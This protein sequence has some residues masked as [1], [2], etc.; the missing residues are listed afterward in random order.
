M[1]KKTAVI[2]IHGIG[3]QVPMETLN[4]FVDTVWT[5]DLSLA[6]A[7]KPDPNTGEV[8]T[9]NAS[10]S[11]PDARN[12]S[13]ELQ[14][15]TTESDSDGRRV[16]FFEY[17]W[18]HRVTGTTWEQV[19]AWL[20]GL[21]L[22]NP[23]TNVPK[24][25]L[26]AWTV[27]WL[28]FFVFL[29]ISLIAGMG[30]SKDVIDPA[31]ASFPPIH[32]TL[33]L[34]AWVQAW[35]KRLIA[36]VWG[37]AG[38]VSGWILTVMVDVAGDVVRYVQATP[39]N[40]AIRQSI[41]ENGVQLLETLMG[42]DEHGQQGRTEYDRIIVVGHSLGTIVAYDILTHAFGRHNTRLDPAKVKGM[43]QEN[44]V[45]LEDLVRQAYLDPGKTISQDVYGALQDAC[46]EELAGIGN[47]WIVSDFISLGSPLTH[48]EFLMAADRDSL[49]LYK[50]KRVLPS[51]P[52]ALEFDQKTG[53]LHFTYRT[54]GVSR[55]GDSHDVE[56]PRMP[57]HSALFAYTRWTNI[58]SPLVGV[59]LGDIV[60]GPVG[61]QFGL[62]RKDNAPPVS[63]IRDIAVLPCAP[64]ETGTAQQDRKRRV[65][66]HLR[67]W[68]CGYARGQAGADEPFHIS[69]LR[70]ALDLGRRRWPQP[71]ATSAAP[72]A[73]PA[74]IVP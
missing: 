62:D 4:E 9:K 52:P 33:A 26:P 59:L 14:L 32:G 47:P 70:D 54:R 46:R 20:F 10:W 41:R 65:L 6:S 49:A 38:L 58:Y 67:Y 39:K 13:F 63:G 21:M 51:C 74:S 72:S 68:D 16:D 5:R 15:V 48:A 30:V 27:M 44:R 22:R 24:G 1:A 60:S 45:A 28:V 73:P 43:T 2:I 8:R 29:Y 56:A 66:T 35:P 12:R 64:T 40:I 18:A 55:E 42:I 57:H 17:Y 71:V 34:A 61:G 11:K 3:E 36:V 23:F 50:E 69:A 7:G 25:V 53:Q 37:V 31:S 19:R